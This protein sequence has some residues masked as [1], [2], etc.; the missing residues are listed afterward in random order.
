MKVK[1]DYGDG[2]E[3]EVVEVTDGSVHFHPYEDDEKHEITV[4][5]LDDE[6][7]PNA[8]DKTYSAEVGFDPAAHTVTEVIGYAEDNPDQIEEILAAE[9]AGKARTTLTSHLEGMR[10]S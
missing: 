7:D 5:A 2:S 9:Q 1:V 3:P 8:P 10:Q 6:Y 4:E